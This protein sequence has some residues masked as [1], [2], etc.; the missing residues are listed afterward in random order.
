[1]SKKVEFDPQEGTWYEKV[2]SPE[3]VEVFRDVVGTTEKTQ[4]GRQTPKRVRFQTRLVLSDKRGH[5]LEVK[6]R[7]LVH[8][9]MMYLQPWTSFGSLGA[10][11]ELEENQPDKLQD[12]LTRA[13]K[14]AKRQLKT[15]FD[16][17]GNLHGIASTIHQQISWA[18]IR[19]LVEGAVKKAYRVVNTPE[20]VQPTANKWT[21][22]M[23][24]QDKHNNVSAWVTVDGGNNII[25]GRSGI[26]VFTR[27]RTDR[28][29]PG[30]APACLNWAGMWSV[31]LQ[32][33]GLKTERLG[34]KESEETQL[35]M[36]ELHLKST[37][38][39]MDEIEALLATK[40]KGM[41]KTV[42]KHM[43]PVIEES[44]KVALTKKEM[45]AILEAYAEKVHLPEYI[46]E[47][48][49]DSVEEST[50]WGF[51]NAVSWCRTHGQF[52]ERRS[53]L[54]REQRPLTQI[55]ENIAG[56]VLSLTPT[57]KKLKAVLPNKTITQKVLTEPQRFPQLK[58]MVA[59]R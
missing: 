53:Q 28:G 36:M 16:D 5:K 6:G 20:V 25:K 45:K 13:A 19:E 14:K 8:R 32:F 29:G 42:E 31:P 50:V 7:R 10:L 15:Y 49:L 43:I 48:I 3:N 12:T 46:I 24:I 22:R 27:L 56:E 17:Q 23:P 34:M 51:S 39:N 1:M 21:Y 33:F 40:M 58:A 30:G 52:D 57:L 44:R 18:R 4:L 9:V 37:A 55:L 41:A 47:Q 11:A 59:K 2:F 38:E 26:R 54:L 35:N